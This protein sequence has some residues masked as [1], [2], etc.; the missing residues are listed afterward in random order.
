MQKISLEDWKNEAVRRFG[1]DPLDWK[2]ICP[3]CGHIQCGKDFQKV[4]RED[5]SPNLPVKDPK[6]VAYQECI[7]RYGG[8][9]GCD[10]AAFGLIHANIEVIT[11]CGTI[12]HV[13]PFA[14]VN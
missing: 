14:E 10:Y 8:P 12:V 1:K 9:G 4:N 11:P 13:F 3:I 2:F 5:K 7:G 6:N